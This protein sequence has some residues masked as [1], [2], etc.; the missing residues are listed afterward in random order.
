MNTLQSRWARALVL[1]ALG[2]LAGAAEEDAAAPEMEKIGDEPF[3]IGTITVDREAQT[4]TVP[5]KILVLKDALEYLAVSRDGMKGYES[6]LELDT[7]P[8]E[9][10][11][12]CI[13]IGLDDKGS[14][15]PRYQFD[16]RVADG[17]AVAITVSWEKDGKT[18]SVSGANA[19][20][21]G[22]DVFDDDS[23]VYIGSEMSHDGKQ[24]MAEIGGTLIGFVHDPYSVIDHR[25]GAGIGAYGLITGNEDAL[26]AKGSAITLTVAV[27]PD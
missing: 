13:L 12:A 20:T 2:S 8:R 23:W 18:R 25:L 15:K 6:L 4:F 19:M 3:R 5:G 14:V 21:T 22:D 11:L 1:L 16:D 17:P 26:P 10:N 24:F 27:V 7:V 9:F